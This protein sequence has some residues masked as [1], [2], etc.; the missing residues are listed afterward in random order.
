MFGVIAAPP[1]AADIGQASAFLALLADPDGAKKRLEE[2]TAATAA[3]EAATKKAEAAE[4]AAREREAA[5]IDAEK[6]AQALFDAADL[7]KRQADKAIF[8]LDARQ[9]RMREIA[10]ELRSL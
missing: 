7:R 3:L 8:E 2:L 6:R 5:A 4:T 9:A 10:A 1:S